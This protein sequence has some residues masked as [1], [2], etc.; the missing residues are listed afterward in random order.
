MLLTFLEDF[1]LEGNHM[2]KSMYK[3]KKIV[4]PLGMDVPRI[5][6]CRNDCILYHGENSNLRQCPECKDPRF[7][8]RKDED[9]IQDDDSD[10]NMNT[11]EA[12]KT[13]KRP[14][15]RDIPEKVCWY[16]PIIPHLKWLY[17]NPETA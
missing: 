9:H 4:C 6:A 8:V 11:A 13:K 12:S 10:D 1:L 7:M 17:S 3:A 5:H 14:N 16:F 2:S 15:W